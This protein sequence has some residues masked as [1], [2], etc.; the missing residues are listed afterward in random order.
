MS[1]VI[2]NSVRSIGNY[3]FYNCYKLVEVVNQST[4][5]TVTKGNT[6]NG[7][8]GYYALTVYNSGN[9]YESKLSNDNGYIVYTDGDKQILVGYTG[10]ETN[11][12]LPSYITQINQ[13]A[14]YNCTS[15]KSVAI[16]DS[17][18]SIGEGA[19]YGCSGLTNIVI[20]EKVTSIGSSAF[21][22]CNA[23][24]EIQYNA[25]NCADFSGGNYAVENTFDYATSIITIEKII[26]KADGSQKINQG[27]NACKKLMNISFEGVIGAGISFA[28]CPLLSRES[29]ENVVSVLSNTTTGTT[30]TFNKA[31]VNVAFTTDEWNALVATK[32][33]WT[34]TLV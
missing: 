31:A 23:L 7:Y 6:S 11:L 13:Y 16:P 24:T 19:F 18:T 1:V 9:A 27:F 4:H 30:A 28:D 14:F 26:I 5:I 12:V 29:I 8:V 25:I 17:V 22:N 3:A 10:T 20:P 34:V 21:Y 33:N 32:P 15:L 2:P